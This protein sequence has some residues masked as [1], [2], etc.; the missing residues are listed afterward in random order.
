MNKSR[1]I[2]LIILVFISCKKEKLTKVSE[3]SSK[4]EVLKEQQSLC[5]DIIIDIIESSKE[6]QEEKDGLLEFLKERGGT[7]YGYM[8]E[9][10]PNPNKDVLVK[11]EYYEFNFH[12]SYPERMGVI[13]RYRFHPIKLILEKYDL[14]KNIY[15]EI[16]YDEN[17]TINF[18]ENCR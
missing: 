10:C 15:F 13:S 4:V 17:L 11:S 6:N 16:N 3:T 18:I 14:V 8:L 5:E 7:S 2:I 12:A 1:L 9:S